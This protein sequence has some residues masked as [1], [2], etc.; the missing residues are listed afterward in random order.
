MK[1]LLPF[2]PSP[3]GPLSVKLPIHTRNWGIMSS[4]KYLTDEQQAGSLTV[5][6][7]SGTDTEELA[8]QK[9][10]LWDSVNSYVGEKIRGLGHSSLQ[11]TL[12]QWNLLN[13]CYTY[14]T[15]LNPSS[16]FPYSVLIK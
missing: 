5:R 8:L 1:E 10:K 11:G 7:L 9:L 12:Q 4:F 13:F 16:D 15:L 2:S 14:D 6:H 3:T